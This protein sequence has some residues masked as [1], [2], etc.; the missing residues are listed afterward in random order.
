[1]DFW[2]FSKIKNKFKEKIVIPST[3]TVIESKKLGNFEINQQKFLIEEK[4]RF[5]DLEKLN[6]INGKKYT[7]AELKEIAVKIGVPVNKK[8]LELVRLIKRKIGAE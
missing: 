4:Y 1:M 2:P 5:I 8:K 7:S 3:N 6:K